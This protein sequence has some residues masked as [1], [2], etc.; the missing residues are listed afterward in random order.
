MKMDICY[1]ME[2]EQD[3]EIE[4]DKDSC[5]RLYLNY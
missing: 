3:I 1:K 5:Q 4:K 2:R